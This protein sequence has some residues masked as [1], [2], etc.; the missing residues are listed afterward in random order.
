MFY[1]LPRSTPLLLPLEVSAPSFKF[2]SVFVPHQLSKHPRRHSD[3]SMPPKILP[4]L[5]NF[6]TFYHAPT[7]AHLQKLGHDTAC[8]G[9]S[10]SKIHEGRANVA[11]ARRDVTHRLLCIYVHLGLTCNASL[12]RNHSRRFLVLLVLDLGG[13]R[14]LHYH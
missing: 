13:Y 3:H 4:K 5:G 1:Q 11:M 7:Q 9:G 14:A 6:T 12:T 10:S 8:V 2:L